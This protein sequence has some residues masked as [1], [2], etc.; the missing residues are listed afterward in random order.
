MKRWLVR[1]IEEYVYGS[2]ILYYIPD[3]VSCFLCRFTDNYYASPVHI[4][5]LSRI[6][7]KKRIKRVSD[8]L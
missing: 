8:E 3:R 5:G 7:D 1:I 2:W 4:N 6:V